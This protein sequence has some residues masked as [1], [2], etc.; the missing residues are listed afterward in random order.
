MRDLDIEGHVTSDNV[1]FDFFDI[2]DPNIVKIDTEITSLA[3]ILAE[4]LNNLHISA[5]LDAILDFSI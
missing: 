2:L 4:L 3:S 1:D 5:I